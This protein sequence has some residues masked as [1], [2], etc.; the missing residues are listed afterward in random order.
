MRRLLPRVRRRSEQMRRVDT[1]L[2][3]K[4]RF[5]TPKLRRPLNGTSLSRAPLFRHVF[6]AVAKEFPFRVVIEVHIAN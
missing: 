5:D 1:H 2:R 3:S 4:L 6:G